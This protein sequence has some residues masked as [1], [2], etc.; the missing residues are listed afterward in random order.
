MF[1]TTR[2][3]PDLIV[4]SRSPY[5]AEPP[6]DRLR[7]SFVTALSDFYVRCHGDIPQLDAARHRLLVDGSVATP[8]DLSMVEL[9]TCFPQRTATAVI[10]CA[11]NRRGDMHEVRPVSGDRWGAGA[12]GNAQWTGVRLSDIL[13]A[14]GV[15]PKVGLHVALTA[16]DDCLAQGE[17]FRYAVSIPLTKAMAPEVLLAYE[18][19]GQP[20]TPEHGSPL[21]AV[22]PGFAGVRSPKW[23]RGIT[24]QDRP[25]DSPVQARDY[26]LF[27]PHVTQETA[28][29]DKGITIYDMPLNAAICEPAPHA[30]LSAGLT[31]VRGYAITT[32]RNIV[33][34]DVS[35]NRGSSWTTAQLEHDPAAPGSWTLWEAT[36]DLPKGDHQLVV[37]AWDSAGQTQP[38]WPNS[39]WNFKGYLSAAWHRVNVNVN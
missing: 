18:M 7:A 36:L 4:R 10:Q 3:K 9:R 33:R 28:D 31:T 22:V 13:H 21:R 8:L 29:W 20:L 1:D 30:E 12:I 15:D 35:A 25:M 11:G 23:L 38:E 27:P 14:A 26:K 39:V 17:R 32:N 24:V 6:L 16:C 5:N 2:A 19:N 34:V 37:R